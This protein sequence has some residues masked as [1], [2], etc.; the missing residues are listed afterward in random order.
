LKERVVKLEE[1]FGTVLKNQKEQQE[2][3]DKKMNKITEMLKKLRVVGFV[4]EKEEDFD[5]S[6]L[7][8]ENDLFLK[9]DTTVESMLVDM[10]CPQSM[11]GRT[12]LEKYLS[13]NKI[14]MEDLEV[15]K[16]SQKFC[17]GPSKV[18]ESTLLVKLPI[19]I[20]QVR[21][22]SS[23]KKIFIEVFVV[24][25]ENAPLLCGKNTMK[26]WKVFLDLD[27]DVMHLDIDGRMTV[28]CVF[29][30]GGH[31]LVPLHQNRNWNTD[32]MVY[33]MNEEG[34]VGCYAKLKKV[35][36]ATNHK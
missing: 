30:A 1:G 33:M 20:K 3:I 10:G 29:S 13:K 14:L 6:I 17:F 24:D 5:E 34:D 9:D 16:C 32:E 31:L 22:E 11:V 21:D 27:K 12:Y 26:D 7:D 18:Y 25:A 8:V 19:T 15:K 4:N 2:S 28:G 36:E 35:Q 23:F